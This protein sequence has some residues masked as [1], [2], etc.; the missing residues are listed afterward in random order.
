MSPQAYA[1]VDE[2]HI[3]IVGPS[4]SSTVEEFRKQFSFVLLLDSFAFLRFVLGGKISV[5]VKTSM[6]R[7]VSKETKWG[8]ETNVWF[9]N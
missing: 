5:L 9:I 4:F 7:L 3:E 8:V 1:R 6:T 2:K